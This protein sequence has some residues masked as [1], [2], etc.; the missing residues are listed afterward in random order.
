[1][2]SLPTARWLRHAVGVPGED[3]ACEVGGP[4]IALLVDHT[5]EDADTGLPVTEGV[6]AANL[7]GPTP[8]GAPGVSTIKTSELRALIGDGER[9]ARGELPLLLSTNC[10]DCMRVTI[11]GTEFVPDPYRNGMLDDAKRFW[12]A[13]NL[14]IELTSHGTAAGWK[15]GTSRASR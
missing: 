10:S 3:Y 12:D 4:F 15:R 9:S 6:R 8:I 14:A 11:P 1:M 13:R 2:G 5:P 7:I